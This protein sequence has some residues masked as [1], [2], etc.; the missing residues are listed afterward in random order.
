MNSRRT[1]HERLTTQPALIG[2]LQTHPN[3]TLAEMA[4]LCGYDF[5]LL[6]GEHG[7]F[8]E[9]DFLLTLQV[10]A[11]TDALA[12]I[13]LAGHDTC[14]VGRYMDLGVD[15]IVVPN[16][17]TV[18]QARA[19]AQAME[20]PPVGTRGAGAALHRA[21]RY[22]LDLAAH[23]QAPRTGVTLLPI[24]ESAFGVTNVEEILAVDGVDGVIVGPSDL[25]A[26]LGCAGDP[27]QPSFA[28]AMASIER[29][30]VGC[31]KLLGT[32][33]YSASP[34][35]ALVAR[36]HRLLIVGSDVSVMREAMLAQ[37]AA[38]RASSA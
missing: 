1:L 35:E 29:A 36:G 21:T 6:D 19:L 11:A 28:Q 32:A 14:A 34:A 38:S 20:Y 24:I 22:G 2:L 31:G 9:R 15:G 7:V 4:G 3:P 10:L 23:L 30:A 12:M 37:V 33:P 26:D 25:S 8:S 16:V 5:V 13:R 17:A 18:E 27:S